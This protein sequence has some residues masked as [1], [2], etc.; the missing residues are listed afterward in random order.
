MRFV[1]RFEP[2]SLAASN[3]PPGGARSQARFHKR[4]IAVFL[5]AVFLMTF[6][7][8]SAF[9]ADPSDNVALGKPAVADSEETSNFGAA[10]AFDGDTTSKAS[11]WS[12]AEDAT[13]SQDG[14]PHWIYVDLEQDRTIQTVCLFWELRKAKGYKI[15][16]AATDSAPAVD[17]D[18]WQT[19]TQCQTT[20]PP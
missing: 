4:L 9:A 19:S 12:T 18:E 14:G 16:V 2:S 20:P 15:Q 11:R 1:Q 3:P 17:S 8:P 6:I 13:P 7:S 5:T 10:K